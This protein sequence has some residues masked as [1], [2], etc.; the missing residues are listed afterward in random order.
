L[1]VGDF[2]PLA[3]LDSLFGVEDAAPFQIPAGEDPQRVRRRDVRQRL[4]FFR[5]EL[6]RARDY[7][8]EALQALVQEIADYIE[9]SVGIEERNQFWSD[10][11]TGWSYD[12]RETR[13]ARVRDLLDRLNN[14]PL[15]D[16]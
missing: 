2:T 5:D 4:R 13:L 8:Q 7:Q 15:V 10:A 3:A 12:S 11:G 16:D 14:L 1:S 9:D 6:G